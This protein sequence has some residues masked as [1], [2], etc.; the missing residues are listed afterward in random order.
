MAD[1]EY[2][3]IGNGVAGITAAQEIRYAD[4]VGRILIVS[5]EGEPY[6]YRAS[7]SEWISGQTT[8]EMLPGRTSEFYDEMDIE[9]VQLYKLRGG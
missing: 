1:V 7:L 4:I 5:D 9:H 3:I 2:L 6:Y 8:D